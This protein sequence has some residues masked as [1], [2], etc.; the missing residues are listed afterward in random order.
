M[1]TH[2]QPDEKIAVL[3]HQPAQS[4]LFTTHHQRQRRHQPG[5]VVE[6]AGIRIGAGHPETRGLQTVQRLHDIGDLGHRHVLDRSRRR[7]GHGRRQSGRTAPG[8]DHAV[9]P[10]RVRRSQDR[11]EIGRILDTVTDQ[12]ERGLTA[13]GGG[14]EDLLDAHD[15]P[16]RRT[17]DHPL[18]A[19][20]SAQVPRVDELDDYPAGFSL[21]QNLADR[22]AVRGAGDKN[23]AQ[24]PAGAQGFEDG[25]P[26]RKGVLTQ[27]VVPRGVTRWVSL[28]P[29]GPASRCATSDAPGCLQR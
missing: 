5:P 29:A 4:A 9:D 1:S 19:G 28:Q 11:T 2:G 26:S 21:P 7:L 22:G 14:G 16:G 8:D 24:C 25:V 3:P 17:G 6:R 27:R 23:L 15:R 20:G 13:R 18:G 10:R 12:H